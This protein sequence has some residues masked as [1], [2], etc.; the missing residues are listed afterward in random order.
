MATT[1]RRLSIGSSN[2]RFSSEAKALRSNSLT[3]FNVNN[4]HQNQNLFVGLVVSPP[5]RKSSMK[6]ATQKESIR[7]EFGRRGSSTTTQMTEGK[8]GAS[9]GGAYDGAKNSDVSTKQ[10][11]WDMLEIREYGRTVGDNPSVSGGPPLT[12]SWKY[13]KTFEGSV[14][15]YEDDRPARRVGKEMAVPR[16]LREIMLCEEWGCSNR[17]IANAVRAILAIKHQR[18]TTINRLEMPGAAMMDEKIEAILKSL[19]RGHCGRQR[20]ILQWDCTSTHDGSTE[21]SG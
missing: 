19:K 11:G 20:E 5:A 18:R 10:V 12:L 3:N 2:R 6:H 1:V 7:C 14:D 17:E 16:Y 15:A 9:A 8:E 21:D 13:N 4:N